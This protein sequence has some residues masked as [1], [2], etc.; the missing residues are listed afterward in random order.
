MALLKEISTRYN[1]NNLRENEE[2]KSLF[3]YEKK[4]KPTRFHFKVHKFQ[5]F[6]VRKEE[7]ETKEN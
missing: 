6:L 2:K 7:D 4:E 1:D 3:F 5:V